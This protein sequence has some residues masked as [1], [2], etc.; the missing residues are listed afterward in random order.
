MHAPALAVRGV[1]LGRFR[2]TDGRPG[3]TREAITEMVAAFEPGT[4]PILSRHGGLWIG[5]LDT[6]RPWDAYAGDLYYTGTVTAYPDLVE[7]LQSGVAVSSEQ[8]YPP[9]DEALGWPGAPH[10]GRRDYFSGKRTGS[11]QLI[12]VALLLNGEQPAARGS[13]MMATA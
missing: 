10:K 2:L 9:W 5:H 4:V 13:W 3:D 1:L 12:G 6:L 8:C 7:R 11:Y